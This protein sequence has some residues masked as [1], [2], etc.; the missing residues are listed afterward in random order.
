MN[1]YHLIDYGYS[2]EDVTTADIKKIGIKPTIDRWENV[3]QD[4]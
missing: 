3:A 1:V 2:Y 4:R